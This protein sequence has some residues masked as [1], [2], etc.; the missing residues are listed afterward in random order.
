MTRH[1]IGIV[2]AGPAG[3]CAAAALHD[4][5][6]DVL[7]MERFSRVQPVGSGLILQPTGQRVL[8]ELFP[9]RPLDFGTPIRRMI[10]RIAPSHRLVLDVNYR[11]LGDEV[12]GIGVHR[13]SLFQWLY[14]VCVRRGIEIKTDVRVK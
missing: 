6:H 1:Q 11:A 14:D 13:A 2:G 4:L 8:T 7:I 10:G 9:E 3:L 5:G 12:Q